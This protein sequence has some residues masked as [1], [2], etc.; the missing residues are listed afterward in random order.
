MGF[1]VILSNPSVSG[2]HFLDEQPLRIK[3]DN[4]YCI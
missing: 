3:D 1:D 2:S 4:N